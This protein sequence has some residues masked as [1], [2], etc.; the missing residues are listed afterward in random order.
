MFGTN[1]GYINEL[2]RE[3][4]ENLDNIEYENLSEEDRDKL[5]ESLKMVKNIA[6]Q[7]NLKTN[8]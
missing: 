2:E 6:I 1:N 5:I 7:L 4:S 3:L 8:H